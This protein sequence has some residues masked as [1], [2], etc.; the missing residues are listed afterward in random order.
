MK[1]KSGVAF[2]SEVQEIFKHAK[3]NSYALPAV[4]VSSTS[5]VNAV[6]ETAAELN[7]PVIVQFSKGGGHFFAGK[8]LSNENEQ[9]A[10][11]G[12]IS[13][14]LHVHQ[15][16]KIYGATIILHTDHCQKSWLTWN[17]GLLEAS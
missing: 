15:M 6:I 9:A 4:N 10:I 13:G 11:N 5:T 2:G 12:C 3:K 17:D 14:A 7:S 1:I 16:A 8:N